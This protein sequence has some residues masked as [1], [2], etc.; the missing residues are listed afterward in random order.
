LD[1]KSIQ[2]FTHTK[3]V[4]IVEDEVL[5]ARAVQKHVQKAGGRL[6]LFGY[7]LLAIYFRY[8]SELGRSG[9]RFLRSDKTAF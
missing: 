2:Y 5:F 7:L 3:K 9:Q 8:Y 6:S 1:L 4:L